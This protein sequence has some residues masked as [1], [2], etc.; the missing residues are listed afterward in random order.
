MHAARSNAQRVK[1]EFRM[2]VIASVRNLRRVDP[3]RAA[4]R[5]QRLYRHLTAVRASS[6][7]SSCSTSLVSG[8]RMSTKAETKE[9]K[10]A[11][12]EPSVVIESK[13]TARA[14]CSNSSR[15][16]LEQGIARVITLNRPKALNSLN[17]DM[18]KILQPFYTRTVAENA[19]RVRCDTFHLLF[20]LS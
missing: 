3:M 9:A 6:P 12:S 10:P 16:C 20:P 8:K 14:P 1:P 18:I 4:S 17:M 2:T 19:D 11:A 13:V 5:T 7:L 15:F